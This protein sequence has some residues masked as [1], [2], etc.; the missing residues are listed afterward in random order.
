[1][2][3][4]FYCIEVMGE[5][6]IKTRFYAFSLKWLRLSPTD[7]SSVLQRSALPNEKCQVRSMHLSPFK[8]RLPRL[9]AIIV[10]VISF[11]RMI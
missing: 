1:M 10:A 6:P 8:K 3:L 2:G 5:G 7:C 4:A 9:V 11:E